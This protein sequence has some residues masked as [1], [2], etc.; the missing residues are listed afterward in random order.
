[1]VFSP[2]YQC[3]EASNSR[4]VWN[5][6]P[7]VFWK[8]MA[9]ISSAFGHLAIELWQWLVSDPLAVSSSWTVFGE[10]IFIRHS[11]QCCTGLVWIPS[12]SRLHHPIF[13]ANP[14]AVQY[15]TP[16]LHTECYLHL[17]FWWFLIVYTSECVT[18][19]TLISK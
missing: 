11:R 14:S 6:F 12:I 16:Y 7:I 10:A 3:C 8:V 9:Y 15:F 17:V 13:M 1:M 18:I 4:N 5:V 19:V 2:L